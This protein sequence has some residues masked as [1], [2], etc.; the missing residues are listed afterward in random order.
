M[1]NLYGALLSSSVYFMYCI[2]E[3]LVLFLHHIN[4]KLVLLSRSRQRGINV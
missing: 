4:K 1:T 3:E 2:N